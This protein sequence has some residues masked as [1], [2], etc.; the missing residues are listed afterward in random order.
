MEEEYGFLD[1][2][3]RML[4]E[5]GEN[6]RSLSLNLNRMEKDFSQQLAHWRESL[7]S[8]QVSQWLEVIRS[9]ITIDTVTVDLSVSENTIWKRDQLKSLMVAIGSLPRLRKL[10]LRQ[11]S[12]GEP[13]RLQ[14]FVSIT[15]AIQ[16]ASL[17]LES[18][19][20][21]GNEIILGTE[22]PMQDLVRA[23]ESCH[24]LRNL[25]LLGFN[26][27]NEHVNLF[28][29]L[30]MIPSLTEFCLGNTCDG[31]LPISET[32]IYSTNIQ[33]LTLCFT[34]EI[35]DSN[36]MA[37]VK[38]LECNTSLQHFGLLNSSTGH[39]TSGIS[40]KCVTALIR[41][42]EYNLTLQNIQ[43]RGDPYDEMQLYVKLNRSGRK[44]L[45]QRVA[46][47]KLWVDTLI[48]SRDDLNCSFYFL[49]MNP[50][51]CVT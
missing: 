40:A 48:T 31:F 36:C 18:L 26:L 32:L 43:T 37:L 27:R 6:F 25:K 2:Q 44:H 10:L 4:R 51:V 41:M 8:F 11:N 12:L 19:E 7:F 14:P 16:E 20:L 23:V 30:M 46:T 3:L 47:H 29:P 33:K 38:V 45:L 13:R 21:W 34:D 9:N 28:A 42:L 15:A 50:S 35:D 49:T 1:T 39:N 24:R 5:K 17:S 22:K